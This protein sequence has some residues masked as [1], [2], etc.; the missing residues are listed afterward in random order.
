MTI[1]LCG[2]SGLVGKELC[3][4][5]NKN[6]IPYIGTYNSNKINSSNMFKINF[7]DYNAIKNLIIDNNIKVCI[8]CIVQRITNIC[9]K[10][11]DEIKNINIDMVHKT[12]LI[13]NEL[14]IRFI[15][16]STDYVFDGSTQPNYPNSDKN[17]LQNYGI[18]KLVSEFKVIKNCTNHCI[19]R[20]PVLYSDL[21]KLHNNAVTLIA[22][23]IMDLSISDSQE[24]NFCI[25]RPLYIPDLCKFIL[26]C[27]DNNRIGIYH[28]YNPYNKYTKFE[29]L[30]QMAKLLNLNYST[31]LPK[32]NQI[33]NPSIAPRPYDTQLIDDKY[34]INK[35]KFTNFI[36]TLS[37]CIGKFKHSSLINHTDKFFLIDLDGTLIDSNL[38]HYNSYKKVFNKYGKKF[39]SIEQW[40]IYVDNNNFDDYIIE[41]FGNELFTKVKNHKNEEYT[42]LDIKFTENADKFINY[43]INNKINYSLPKPSKECYQLALNRYYNKEKYIIGI[44]DTYAGYKSL[45]NI[46]DIIYIFKNKNIFNKEDCYLFDNF[47]QLLNL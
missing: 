35:Y 7:S 12:S 23:K 36:D 45:R 14:N 30:E 28:F 27:L 31:I 8:F 44:E 32:N 2:A 20:T 19:I 17:P 3:K 29:I 5:F 16:L 34:D 43:I 38:N 10:K 13:C 15:H 6:K 22:K 25:R 41:T 24:D 21:S 18:S 46:T 1:L 33:I 37:L 39:L 40:N 47:D 4:I 26:D 11:W 42:K 9:E